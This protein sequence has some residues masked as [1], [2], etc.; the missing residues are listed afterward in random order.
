MV[1]RSGLVWGSLYLWGYG[2]HGIV[3]IREVGG[4]AGMKKFVVSGCIDR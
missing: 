4:E 1:S 2:M 3:L